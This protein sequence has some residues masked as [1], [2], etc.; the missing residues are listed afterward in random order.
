LEDRLVPA[1][2]TTTVIN[3]IAASVFSLFS[4]QETVTTQT[5][6][7]A[8]SLAAT[9]GMVTITDNGQTHIVPVNSAGAASTTFTFSFFQEAPNP[10]PVNASYS[11]P[12]G[13]FSSS[14]AATVQAPNNSTGYLFQ[15]FFDLALI[16]ALST[17]M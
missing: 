3:P 15:V 7:T 10:H 9:K 6:I 14:T 5:N 8:T 1:L 4:Q 12:T 17:Q 13:V 16:Q 11:D 2:P